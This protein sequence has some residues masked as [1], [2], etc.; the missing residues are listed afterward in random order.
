MSTYSA[1]VSGIT[2]PSTTAPDAQVTLSTPSSSF[3]SRGR[4]L[5]SSDPAC[6]NDSIENLQ[7]VHTH[8]HHRKTMSISS[9]ADPVVNLS[10]R[11]SFSN[12]AIGDGQESPIYQIPQRLGRDSLPILPETASANKDPISKPRAKPL[13]IS[14]QDTSLMSPSSQTKVVI[15]AAGKGLTISPSLAR[16]PSSGFGPIRSTSATFPGYSCFSWHSP[17]NSPKTVGSGSMTIGS[18][19]FVAKKRGLA[20]AIVKDNGG[21]VPVTPSLGSAGLRSPVTGLKSAEV[22]MIGV[23]KKDGG[24]GHVTA[25]PGLATGRLDSANSS[26]LRKEI[27]LCKFYHTPGLTCTSRPCRFVHALSSLTSPLFTDDISEYAMLSPTRPTDPTSG[28]FAFAQQ[29]ISQVPK[30]LKVDSNGVDL[31]G[32]K[33]GERVVL[34]DENGQEVAGQV[35]LMSGGGKGIG[36]K[37]KEK[38]K[39][40]GSFDEKPQEVPSTDDESSHPG[41]RKPRHPTNFLSFSSKIVQ[42]DPFVPSVRVDL[43][44]IDKSRSSGLSASAESFS[45]APVRVHH[46]EEIITVPNTKRTV[47]SADIATLRAHTPPASTTEPVS[48]PMAVATSAPPES[49]A[50]S[51]GPPALIKKVRSLK[52]VTIAD[53]GHKRNLSVNLNAPLKTPTSAESLAVPMSAMSLWTESDPATPFDPMTHRK[54]MLEIEKEAKENGHSKAIS[55]SSLGN[56]AFDSSPAPCQV[57]DPSESFLPFMARAY[58]WGMPMS[59]ISLGAYHD[60]LASDVEGGLGVIWTPAGWAVQDAAMKHALRSAEVQLKF[61]NVKRRKPKSY[62]RTR[63]C[64]FFAEGHCPHGKECTFIHIIPGSSPESLSSSDSDAANSKSKEQSNK[65]KTLPC[66]FFN[67]AAGCNAGDDC[68]FLHTRVVPESVPLVTK[69]RPWRT[70]PCRHYQLG[71]CMLGD[72]CHFAHVNDPAWVASGWKT[73]TVTP[74]KI[75]NVLEQ[76]TAEK[77]EKAIERIREMSRGGKADDEEDDEE[78][79][80]Q[81]HI[82]SLEL[83]L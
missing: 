80:I 33:M 66:K 1:S 68:A 53:I 24:N 22:K 77:V 83:Q 12:E 72:V 26:C 28:T 52:K 63:P 61:E 13:P 16:K 73:G 32:L 10:R 37:G 34:E 15:T 42:K 70:K 30:Q 4:G 9:L 27:I 57:F 7:G 21:V 44:V 35:F 54:K 47:S 25:T 19:A 60:S 55:K 20:I 3:L 49:N 69:P 41:H 6:D 78:D 65:R 2:A 51:K 14:H 38:Y 8:G 59:P 17:L 29:Q 58:P 23:T 64:K 74:V 82:E 67:S 56:L 11:L 50:W 36:G 62:Y 46:S 39:S 76:L 48:V 43:E 71:R 40:D 5:Q 18:A 75:E 79:D 81:I 45:Q 31:D